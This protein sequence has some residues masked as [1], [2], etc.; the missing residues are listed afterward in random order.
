MVILIL[1]VRG[2]TTDIWAAAMVGPSKAFPGPFE[3]RRHILSTAKAL[4]AK[5]ASEV[6]LNFFDSISY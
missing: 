5:S 1:V 2:N 4:L 3:R 6:L